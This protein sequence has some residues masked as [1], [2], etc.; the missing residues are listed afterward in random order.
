MFER[1]SFHRTTPVSGSYSKIDFNSS[2]DSVTI[3]PVLHFDG[4]T[5]PYSEK[6]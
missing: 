3:G 6:W 1:P 4:K 5:L 2:C